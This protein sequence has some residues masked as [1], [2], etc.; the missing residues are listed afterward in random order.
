MYFRFETADAGMCRWIL[1]TTRTRSNFR[2]SSSC[3]WLNAY[4]MR[5][6]ITTGIRTYIVMRVCNSSY[7][8]RG[9]FPCRERRTQGQGNSNGVQL[10]QLQ[11]TSTDH[12]VRHLPGAPAGPRSALMYD[13][14]QPDVQVLRFASSRLRVLSNGDP[15]VA[16]HCDGQIAR[17]PGFALQ[18][19]Q[20]RSRARPSPHFY[21]FYPIPLG[22]FTW[23]VLAL[24][25]ALFPVLILSEN[26][27]V[28]FKAFVGLSWTAMAIPQFSRFRESQ[29]ISRY[30]C[31]CVYLYSCWLYTYLHKSAYYNEQSYLYQ[32]PRETTNH[33]ACTMLIR[34]CPPN[35][36]GIYVHSLAKATARRLSARP[37][38]TVNQSSSKNPRLRSSG[39]DESSSVFTQ[40]YSIRCVFWKDAGEN[41][42][43]ISALM[44]AFHVKTMYRELWSLWYQCMD[45]DLRDDGENTGIIL[46]PQRHCSAL[47][48]TYFEEGKISRY[49]SYIHVAPFVS[50]VPSTWHDPSTDGGV[51]NWWWATFGCSTRWPVPTVH[52]TVPSVVTYA[53][54]TGDWPVSKLTSK[55]STISNLWPTTRSPSRYPGFGERPTLSM[56][57][58]TR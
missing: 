18:E 33:Y 4:R 42:G 56:A 40:W 8:I 48:R 57:N 34:E 14:R 31:K 11:I 37:V 51:R 10:R 2:P 6:R 5:A 58:N 35:C 32:V 1:R 9:Y 3:Y 36:T 29:L 47:Q 25:D 38:F 13:L 30:V 19:F 17:S 46:I 23:I 44:I 12:G 7:V 16:E 53:D 21:K 50:H 20:V 54:G 24:S 22:T 39:Y 49:R 55:T 27:P 52:S 43:I 45:R 28:I 15:L 41:C 26:R